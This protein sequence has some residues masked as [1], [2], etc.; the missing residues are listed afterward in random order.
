[1]IFGDLQQSSEEFR[2]Y[3]EVNVGVSGNTEKLNMQ[4]PCPTPQILTEK[5]TMFYKI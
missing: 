2:Q 5:P 4:F 1:M 3:S